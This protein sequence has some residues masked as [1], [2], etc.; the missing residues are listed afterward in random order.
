VLDDAL[1]PDHLGGISRNW[2]RL[3]FGR[4][5]PGMGAAQVIA[6]QQGLQGLP[7]A[8]RAWLKHNVEEVGNLEFFLPAL[9]AAHA[10]Q[11]SPELKE[12]FLQ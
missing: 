1:Q 11:S 9:Y 4:E 3:S 6:A 5:Q 2:R 10:G 8:G 7:Q 12:G